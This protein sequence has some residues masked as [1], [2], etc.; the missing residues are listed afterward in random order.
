MSKSILIA[1]L[2]LVGLVIVWTV[3]AKATDTVPV[4]VAKVKTG[5]I[6][7][8]VDERAETRLPRVYLI[9][10]P[11]T[12][13]IE[14]NDL[15]EGTP[16]QKGQVVA[17]VVPLDIEL[18]MDAATAAVERLD[19]AIRENDDTSVEKTGLMQAVEFVRSMDRTVEAAL[20]R[21]ESGKAKRDFATKKLA[22]AKGLL[23]ERAASL[24]EFDRAEFE[25][26]ESRVD[27]RQ[28][29]L[30]HSAMVAMQ[31]ATRLMPTMVQQYI[32]R[33]ALSHDVL[34]KQRAEAVANLD[35]TKQDKERGT[36]VSPVD[37][38]VLD[39][40]VSNE[41]YLSA[42]TVLL[43]IGNLE[44]LEVEADV[45]SQ[46]VVN[47]KHGNQVEVY[48]PA[49]GKPPA[50]AV[51]TQI[52]PAGFTK[53]SSLGVEQQRV[54]VVMKMTPE[55]LRRTLDQR[56]LGVGYRVRVRVYTAEKQRALTIP[57]S[58]LFRG[59]N[60]DWQVF[61]VRGGRAK[62]VAIQLGLMNDSIVEVAEGLGDGET[63]VLAPEVGLTDGRR[64]ETKAPGDESG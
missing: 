58:A 56:G 62:R 59:G 19:A 53:V 31:A 8:F 52:H 28:D 20:A 48:G 45:L 7:E 57:R 17:R 55:D 5:P 41:R 42:G 36:L 24:E 40:K 14:Q 44:D 10:M 4:L 15:T 47:V 1:M 22:R 54:K 34:V 6:Q 61:A 21:V 11:Y 32:D 63:V 38:V 30:V 9:T 27:L 3:Y 25:M 64:V 12:A 37:G 35:Q 23:A 43:E 51:V 26:V 29:E 46:D 50:R 16:V 49:I 39:R 2:L 13:R 33:K 18:S 60:G